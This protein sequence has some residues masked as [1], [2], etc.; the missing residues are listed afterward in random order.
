M[1]TS[2]DITG[3]T[4]GLSASHKHLKRMLVT[5]LTSSCIHGTHEFSANEQIDMMCQR[6]YDKS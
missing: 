1:I 5:Q 4:T 2:N 3:H 6:N